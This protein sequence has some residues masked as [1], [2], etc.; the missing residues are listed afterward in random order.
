[1]TA[2]EYGITATTKNGYTEAVCFNGICRK[3]SL[4]QMV[5]ELFTEESL[6]LITDRVKHWINLIPNKDAAVSE[7]AVA[8]ALGWVLSGVNDSEGPAL[9]ESMIR[10]EFASTVAEREQAAESDGIS[11]GRFFLVCFEA[12]FRSFTKICTIVDALASASSGIADERKSRIAEEYKSVLDD[13]F[14]HKKRIFQVPGT[15]ETFK[16]T[17]FEELL[18]FEYHRMHEHGKVFKVCENCGRYFAPA[19]RN[20]KYCGYPS[21][22]D[23]NIPCRTMAPRLR[24]SHN[25]R[26]DP[27]KTERNRENARMAAS[28]KRDSDKW[29]LIKQHQ[30]EYK[31]D[32]TT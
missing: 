29:R 10:G 13:A 17:R 23:A 8:S 15:E 30:Q 28:K 21:P 14:E 18:L 27:E 19:K 4:G 6:E 5:L 12:Y 31:E 20:T 32:N 22:Q 11:I 25:R 24:A 7:S 26:E 1:M 16:L 9:T 2:F 3:F